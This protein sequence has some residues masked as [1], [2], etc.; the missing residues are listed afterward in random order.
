MARRVSAVSTASCSRSRRTRSRRCRRRRSK[1]WACSCTRRW[2]SI[3][4]AGSCTRLKTAPQ[5]GCIGSCPPCPG[6]L[7][8][9]AAC[10]CSRSRIGPGTTLVPVSVWGGRCRSS[11]WTSPTRH[12]RATDSAMSHLCMRKVRARVGQPSR[13][14][15]DA[16]ITAEPS[17]SPRRAAATPVK[18]RCGRTGHAAGRADSWSSCS[19]RAARRSSTT[20]TT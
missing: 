18:G 9:A 15:K 20:L 1:D 17:G 11:G 13:A 10:R 6:T 14:V 8:R 4:R 7:R 5:V 12:P 19:S 3:R 16:G 2:R